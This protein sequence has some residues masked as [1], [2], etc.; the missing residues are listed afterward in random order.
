MNLVT[1]SGDGTLTGSIRF[2]GV[3]AADLEMGGLPLMGKID[4]VLDIDVAEALIVEFG[5]QPEM[6][7]TAVDG[8]YALRRGD[9]VVSKIEYRAGNL[10]INGKSQGIPGVGGAQPGRNPGAMAE[11][12]PPQ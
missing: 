7:A 6:V 5:G 12:T 2:K 10:K 3:T 4:A 8:G 1:K 11:E 9:R